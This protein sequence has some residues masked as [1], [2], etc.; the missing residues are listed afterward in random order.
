MGLLSIAL[1]ATTFESFASFGELNPRELQ[2]SISR[3]PASDLTNSASRQNVEARIQ[4]L[5]PA[6]ESGNPEAMN[7]LGEC[8][9]LAG[10]PIEAFAWYQRSASNGWVV[11]QFNLAVS[12]AVG[13]GTATNLA[14]ALRWYQQA[15][16]LG[17]APA[18]YNLGNAYQIGRAHV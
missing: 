12:Y 1:S 5:L 14:E 18:Q 10:K 9:D 13:M 15:A 11:A 7:L 16:T 17:Y 2:D 6:A 8:F 4:K 3:R